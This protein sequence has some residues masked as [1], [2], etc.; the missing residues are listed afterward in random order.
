V[1]ALVA[2]L[3]GSPLQIVQQSVQPCGQNGC[4]TIL[5][6]VS[7]DSPGVF[8]LE[9]FASRNAKTDHW[10]RTGP[11]NSSDDADFNGCSEQENRPQGRA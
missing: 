7:I 8:T 5:P 2:S 9:T 4:C 10:G 11:E 3:A 1:E 6:K